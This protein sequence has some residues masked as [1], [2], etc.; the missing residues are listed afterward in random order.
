MMRYYSLQ[1][2]N[3]ERKCYDKLKKSLSCLKPE[4]RFD[5]EI[6]FDELKKIV[7]ALDCEHPEIF[8]VDYNSCKRKK[9]HNETW[10]QLKYYYPKSEIL[11]MSK[12]LQEILENL[13]ERCRKELVRMTDYNI[14]KWI[15]NYFVS[16]VLY[17]H[18]IV[19]RKGFQIQDH[20]IVGVLTGNLSV[21]EGI[22]KAYKLLC[23]KLG[24]SAMVV[25]GGTTS[26][27]DQNHE[28]N[29]V[30]ID[31]RCVHVDVTWDLNLS[32]KSQS[33]RYDYFCLSDIEMR[34]NHFYSNTPPCGYYPELDFFQRNQC[35]F[36]RIEELE[37]YIE[38]KMK[39]DSKHKIF[40][41]KITS[42]KY[43]S[44]KQEKQ[45]ERT[46]NSIIRIF[47]KTEWKYR[48]QFINEMSICYYRIIS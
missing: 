10:V 8:Y 9:N 48:L 11:D 39:S 12:Q 13:A 40:Y 45:L 23:E 35:A 20:N 41:F 19:Q 22:A 5:R 46:I 47:R 6:S 21:C 24:V 30:K 3:E 4:V 7:N 1:L 33:Y 18:S 34:K 38:E 32:Q 16:N 2:T 44:E 37:W 25:P 17:H 42:L 31:G 29:I 27:L 14:C 15:H 43:I 26:L 28:W 36:E